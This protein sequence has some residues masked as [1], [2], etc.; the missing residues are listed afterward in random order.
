MSIRR[1]RTR[2]KF[3]NRPAPDNHRELLRDPSAAPTEMRVMAYG[4]QGLNEN[5]SPTLEEIQA[6]AKQYPVVWIDI[7]GLAD[8]ELIQQIGNV[9]SIHP[10]VQEDIVRT[11]QRAKLEE[12]Q[13]SV[14]IVSRMAPCASQEDTEQLAIYLT[15]NCVLTFQEYPDDDLDGVRNRIRMEKGRIR[16]EQPDYLVYA[17]IDAVIDAYFPIV[18]RYGEMI[19]DLEDQLVLSP[20]RALLGNIYTVRRKLLELRRALW[21]QRE[22]LATLYRGE[23]PYIRPETQVYLRDC[24]DHVV[25]LIDLMENYRELASNL[26]DVYLSSVSNRLNEIM[27]VLTIIS[28]IFIPLTF[29]VGVYGMNFRPESSP[30]NMPEIV[31]YYGYPIC[32]LVMILI[33]IFQ[34]VYFWKK[35]W[36]TDRETVSGSTLAVPP[37][38]SPV[39]PARKTDA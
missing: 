15:G 29:I 11:H 4:P 24:Y 26:M 33:S 23:T 14:F 1:R 21:P 8:V 10:L 16:K 9:F 6:L 35:G 37:P 13:D 36:L 22:L 3:R 5:A 31:S 38:N 25:Q 17:I 39:D 30:W 28:A 34:I 18:D 27:K 32:W 20:S 12:Y 7:A 2:P 19:E